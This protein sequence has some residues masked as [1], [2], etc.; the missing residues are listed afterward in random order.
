[1]PGVF[2]LSTPSGSDGGGFGSDHR[3]PFQERWG[4]WYVTGFSSRFRHLGNRTGQGWLESLYDQFNMSGYLT[5][6]S[7][8]V[9][10]MAFEHQTH[11]ANLI[12][13]LGREARRGESGPRLTDA[14]NR[15]VDYLLFVDEAPLPSRIIGT[16]GFREKFE[17]LGPYDRRGRSLRQFDLN[18]RMMRY[19]CSYM[20]Y[21]KA[22]DALPPGAR[23][24][25]YA[26]IWDILAERSEEPR[27]ARMTRADRKAVF[28]I[29]SD[30]KRDFTLLSKHAGPLQASTTY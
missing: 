26:R 27:Y 28:Q 22:F 18:R 10:L 13:L 12:T 1:M 6:Y 24:S 2:V 8:M 4:G 14:V 29:L 25:V 5:E 7:D 15:L 20:I 3:T 19:Q 9:A 11:A 17:A 21:S 23:Q 30:T 16:S